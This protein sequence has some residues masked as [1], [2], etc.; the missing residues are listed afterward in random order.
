M[1]LQ[2]HQE[3]MTGGNGGDTYKKENENRAKST[4]KSPKQ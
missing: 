3:N 4:R 1:V 2:Y